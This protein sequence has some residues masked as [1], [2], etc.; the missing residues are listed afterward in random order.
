M[1]V[2]HRDN[3]HTDFEPAFRPAAR[4][5][6][7]SARMV[8]ISRASAP[9]LLVRPL[10]QTFIPSGSF[11]RDRISSV[12]FHWNLILIT[13][14]LRENRSQDDKAT[15]YLRA[16]LT[17][18]L[19]HG[20]YKT[21]ATKTCLSTAFTTYVH[22]SSPPDFSSFDVPFS[23]NKANGAGTLAGNSS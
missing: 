7:S 13:C 11:N 22:P 18:I 19:R 10:V 6:I 1:C 16:L 21:R 5:A 17:G 3:A 14:F 15:R 9:T 12:S 4:K 2:N 23:S 8:P 20:S